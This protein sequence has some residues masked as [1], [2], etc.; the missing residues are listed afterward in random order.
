MLSF[1]D[2]SA[3]GAEKIEPLSPSEDG[4]ARA[5]QEAER[6]TPD[7]AFAGGRSIFSMA[8]RSE[9]ERAKA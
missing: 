7:H 3:D 6:F 8:I 9:N 4:R 2:G 5:Q 1:H